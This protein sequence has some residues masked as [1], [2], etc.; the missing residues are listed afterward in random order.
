MRRAAILLLVAAAACGGPKRPALPSGDGVP[1]PGF[2]AAY[3][4]AIQECRDVTAI[5]AQLGLSG[6]AGGTKLRGRIN[7]YVAAPDD[8]ILEGLAPFGKPVFVLAGRAGEATLVLPRDERVLRGEAPS[9]IVEALAGIA[10]T[11]SE[12]RTAL[13]GCGLGTAAPSGGRS[14]GEDWA[15]VD[16]ADGTMFLQ[17]VGG[18]WRVAASRREAITVQ[19]GEFVSG[20]ASTVFV[21]TPAS[22]LALRVSDVELNTPIDPSAFDLAVPRN[23]VPLTLDELRRAGPLG[24][25]GTATIRETGTATITQSGTATIAESAK[26]GCPRLHNQQEMAVS[27]KVAVPVSENVA[28]PVFLIVAVHVWR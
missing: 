14:F 18:R 13:A 16:V 8:I 28:V 25:K 19:Y 6:R 12:L 26:G 4:Q 15:S 5:S 22:D 27:Q 21:R 7:A 24:E 17:R 10:L 2:A 23:A 3:E 1:F 11:P 20:R 9:A